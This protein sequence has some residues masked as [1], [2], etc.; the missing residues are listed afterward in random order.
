MLKALQQNRLFI[1]S[2]DIA[3][4]VEVGVKKHVKKHVEMVVEEK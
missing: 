1:T 2:V 3:R 4:L